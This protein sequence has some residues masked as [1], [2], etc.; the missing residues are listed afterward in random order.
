MV[1]T[2]D[3]FVNRLTLLGRK[4]QQ[5]TH[6][7]TTKVGKDGLIVVRP[8]R[9]ARNASGLKVVVLAVALFFTL[10]LL[11][12]IM[13]GPASYQDRLS[14]LENGTVFERTGAYL[15]GIDPVTQ[16]VSDLIA[17]YML[18]VLK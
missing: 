5:L 11:M 18:P 13:V 17:P 7:Y 10:K 4:H 9:T 3:H 12:V 2:H 16:K 14:G 8:K 15:M 6:G 1:E